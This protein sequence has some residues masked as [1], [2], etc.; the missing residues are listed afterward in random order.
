[1]TRDKG[2]IER[3]TGT[4]FASAEYGVAFVAGDDQI[5]LRGSDSEDLLHHPPP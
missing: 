4:S 2:E 5:F 3:Q 1:V